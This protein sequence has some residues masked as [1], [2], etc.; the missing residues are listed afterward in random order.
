MIAP[1]DGID[2]LDRLMRARVTQA[3]VLPVG[4]REWGTA[5]PALLGAPL[6]RTLATGPESPADTSIAT[7]SLTREALV[8]AGDG[9]GPLLLTYV[10]EQ[11]ARVLGCEP[12]EIDVDQS[13]TMMGLDSLM[14]VEL[15]N[16][17]EADLGVVLPL[18]Q[19][20]DGFESRPARLDP[21][22]QAG[23]A[24]NSRSSRGPRDRWRRG[25]RGPRSARGPVGRRDRS[26]ARPDGSPW[27]RRGVSEVMR[28]AN[29]LTLDGKRARLEH[30]LRE[31]AAR[32]PVGDSGAEPTLAARLTWQV[33][34]RFPSV[35]SASGSSIS[36]PRT[37]RPTTCP[38]RWRCPGRSIPKASSAACGRWW[39]VTRSCGPRSRASTGSRSSTS[40]AVGRCRCRWW[41]WRRCRRRAATGCS[42]GCW[43]PRPAGPSTWSA[44]PSG[45]ASSSA[46]APTAT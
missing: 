9:S 28:P 8:A 6:L 34:F 4:S 1:Q 27:W 39:R 40:A 21:A 43:T 22:Q 26:A 30:L 17:F 42:S 14:A 18:V 41:T 46:R 16:R 37:C 31:R 10:E 2:A 45:A 3:V 15:K 20:L 13:I 11:I 29:E 33:R 38:C 23:P 24:D 35:R 32:R 36:S 19:Y 25:D 5:Y 7:G 44:G 12:D